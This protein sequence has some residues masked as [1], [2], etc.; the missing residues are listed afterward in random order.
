MNRDQP[1][2]MTS[3]TRATVDEAV[4]RRVAEHARRREAERA[5]RARRTAARA[6]GL[7]QRHA[8]KL[9]RLAAHPMRPADPMDSP[10][11]RATP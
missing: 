10:K 8:A 9:A 4:A 1:D 11:E 7:R 3:L 6:Y 5:A 2:D